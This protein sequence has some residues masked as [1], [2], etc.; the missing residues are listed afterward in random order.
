MGGSWR[1]L[2]FFL[3]VLEFDLVFNFFKCC[4]IICIFCIYWLFCVCDFNLFSENVDGIF[5]FGFI[6][7]EV[8]VIVKLIECEGI[9]LILFLFGWWGILFV[10]ERGWGC[11]F[12]EIRLF[13]LIECK[14]W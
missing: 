3:V 5:K 9:L 1:W 10:V 4:V 11:G 8:V 14:L 13:G 6:G 2:E 7:V 12:E